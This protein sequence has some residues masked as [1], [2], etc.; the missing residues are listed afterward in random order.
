V[1]PDGVQLPGVRIGDLPAQSFEFLQHP[2]PSQQVLIDAPGKGVQLGAIEGSVVADPAAHLSV[3]LSCDSGQVRP[4][5]TVDTTINP[6]STT[7]R[8]TQPP[9]SSHNVRQS[10]NLSPLADTWTPSSHSCTTDATPGSHPPRSY[11]ANCGSAAATR[12]WTR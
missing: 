12:D 3:D 9:K 6:T 5:A 1:K 2:G 4:T 10:P 11:T 8:R 7:P